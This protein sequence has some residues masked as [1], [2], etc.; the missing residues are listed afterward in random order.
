MSFK[1]YFEK[2]INPLRSK[3]VLDEYKEKLEANLASLVIKP[4]SEISNV[5]KNIVNIFEITKLL[6]ELKYPLIDEF[7]M[8]IRTGNSKKISQTRKEFQQWSENNSNKSIINY[9]E[10]ILFKYE[11]YLFEDDFSPEQADEIV[12]SV[13]VES[14][15]ILEQMANKIDLAIEKCINWDNHE[16]IIE[17]LY[18]QKGLIVS[19]AKIS[20][21]NINFIMNDNFKIVENNSN[22]KLDIADLLNK[23]S[24]N[25]KYNKILTLYM[26]RPKSERE[27]FES[28]KKDLS[29]GIEAVLP[30]YVILTTIPLS[31]NTDTWKVR[32]DEKYIRE[33]LNEGNY[34]EFHILSDDVPIKWIELK[35]EK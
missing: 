1:K 15:V 34:K 23:L 2:K 24:E 30:N 25:P 31:E 9:I 8:A 10:S 3:V 33:Y 35:N 19:E 14:R 29:L 22:L 12:K 6:S 7:A 28:I 26:N 13:L 20:V 21:G 11:T 27:Y 16:I 32:I 4:N 5:K 17:A 18:P